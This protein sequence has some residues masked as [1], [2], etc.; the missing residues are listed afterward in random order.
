MATYN[1]EKLEDGM[2]DLYDEY[3][4]LSLEELSSVGENETRTNISSASLPPTTIAIGFDK[5]ITLMPL[6][7]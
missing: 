3:L 6:L 1:L 2:K 4:A 7:Q 5:L